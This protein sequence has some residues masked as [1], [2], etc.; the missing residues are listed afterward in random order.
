[1]NSPFTAQ[2]AIWI[3]LINCTFH[4]IDPGENAHIHS[5]LY[6]NLEVHGLLR[7]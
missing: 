7:G 4:C 1:M 5:I 6:I 2:Q 3:W